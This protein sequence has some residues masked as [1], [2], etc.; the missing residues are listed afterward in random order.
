VETPYLRLTERRARSFLP[1]TE[2]F[3]SCRPGSFRHGRHR[4]EASL[5]QGTPMEVRDR[6]L[7]EAKAGL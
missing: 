7:E 6:M 5:P 2:P 1:G 4:V 3:S